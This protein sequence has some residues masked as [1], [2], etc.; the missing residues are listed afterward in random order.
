MVFKAAQLKILILIKNLSNTEASI[1]EVLHS[2]FSKDEDSSF[3]RFELRRL[4]PIAEHRDYNGIR[5]KLVAHIKKTRT[6][7]DVDM[8]VGD[9]IVPKPEIK[10]L[11]TQLKGFVSPN[12]YVYSLEST[13]AEKFDAIIMRLELTSRMKDYFDIYYLAITYPF[14]GRKLQ[15]AIFQTLQKRG[16]PFDSSTLSEVSRFSEDPYMFAKWQH[17]IQNTLK[18][19]VDFKEVIEIIIKFVGPAF[20]SIIYETELLKEW[21]SETLCYE[22]YKSDADPTAE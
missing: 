16:T 20:N 12:I 3:I 17:F 15:E 21:N 6:P 22:V 7:F 1:Y 8:G 9:I 2:I 4:E 14:D 19:S 11:P 5:A 13:I 10:S 18:Y